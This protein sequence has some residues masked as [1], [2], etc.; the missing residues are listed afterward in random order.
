MIFENSSPFAFQKFPEVAFPAFSL[1]PPIRNPSHPPSWVG[2][3]LAQAPH[4]S[5]YFANVSPLAD[6]NLTC[7][8]RIGSSST[9]SRKL[10]G[11]SLVQSVASCIM[12]PHSKH[13]GH[14][15]HTN[16]QALCHLPAP[17]FPCGC[18]LILQDSTITSERP[19]LTL[20]FTA[21]VLHH[22]SI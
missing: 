6:S 3:V 2:T 16:T 17:G 19:S 10:S 22:H 18:L 1:T 21:Q 5:P 11:T 14:T 7:A 13:S 8:A 15:R 20:L 9:L 4:S 12:S